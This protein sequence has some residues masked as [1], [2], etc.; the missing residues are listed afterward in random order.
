MARAQTQSIGNCT[1]PACLP[2]C[3]LPYVG[4]VSRLLTCIRSGQGADLLVRFLYAAAARTACAL[5]LQCLIS[6][7][8]AALEACGV[9]PRT[10]HKPTASRLALLWA[11]II[12]A[13]SYIVLQ[14][15]MDACWD[16]QWSYATPNIY[17]LCA[18]V[19][20]MT[21]CVDT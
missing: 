2:S 1:T 15:I 6:A 10:H 16:V 5:C 21:H 12:G 17:M 4:P 20:L 7:A 8:V 3:L 9:Y 13:G 18:W 14:A 19:L 11:N